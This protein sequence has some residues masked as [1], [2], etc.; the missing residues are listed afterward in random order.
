M[1]SHPRSVL[2]KKYI[3]FIECTSQNHSINEIE[4]EGCR[5]ILVN[6]KLNIDYIKPLLYIY[7][8]PLLCDFLECWFPI[9]Y[10][11]NKAIL[12]QINKK[13]KCLERQGAEEFKEGLLLYLEKKSINK[14]IIGPLKENISFLESNLVL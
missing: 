5:L 13:K 4:F 8:D 1:F 7:K 12:Q 11:C 9:G 2:D 6:G 3:K 14:D 10:N